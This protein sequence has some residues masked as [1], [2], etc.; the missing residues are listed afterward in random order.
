MGIAAS[1]EDERQ[2]PDYD[3]EADQKDDQGAFAQEFEHG[4]LLISTEVNRDGGRS[5]P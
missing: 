4:V 5:V 2:E 3:G 1:S